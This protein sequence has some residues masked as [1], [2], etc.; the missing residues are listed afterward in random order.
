MKKP[1]RKPESE[2]ATRLYSFVP[3][4]QLRPV[5]APRMCLYFGDGHLDL[6][7]ASGASGD[8]VNDGL[9]VYY[10]L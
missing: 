9:V 5:I 2:Q 6:V 7:A 1:S 8:S 4:I 3:V 10:L